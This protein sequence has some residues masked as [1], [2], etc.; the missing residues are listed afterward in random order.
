MN[1][2]KFRIK[3][4]HSE[5]DKEVADSFN[6]YFS[7]LKSLNL[8]NEDALLKFF[9][10]DF[11]HD[12]DIYDLKIFDGNRDVTFK[13]D[14]LNI[15]TR[16]SD[17]KDCEYVNT[18][19]ECVFRDV[20]WLT[21]EGKRVDALNDPLTDHGGLEFSY[22]EIDTLT[23]YIEHFKNNYRGSEV[24]VDDEPEFH[25]IIIRFTT[26]SGYYSGN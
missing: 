24:F 14:A 7:H 20:V 12:G 26:P 22:S 4:I 21:M 25:S 16:E 3:N 15:R 11:F 19:F 13:I 8:K 9:G 23:E 2:L 5:D 1:E 6:S 10:Y 18:A 17:S